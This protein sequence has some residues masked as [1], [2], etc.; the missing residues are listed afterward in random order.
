MNYI[1]LQNY[2]K[3]L[4]HEKNVFNFTVDLQAV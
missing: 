3:Y 4:N 1:W 2:D